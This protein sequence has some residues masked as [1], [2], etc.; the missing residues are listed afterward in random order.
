MANVLAI[1]MAFVDLNMPELNGIDLMIL[2][3]K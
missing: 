3:R 2:V 1:D